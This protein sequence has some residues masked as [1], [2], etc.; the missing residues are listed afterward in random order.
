MNNKCA[1]VTGSAGLVGSA[2]ADL[3]CHHGWE[4]VGIDNFMRAEFFGQEAHTGEVMLDLMQRHPNYRHRR[5]DIRSYDAYDDIIQHYDLVV[6]CAGQP[7][8]DLAAKRP[9][10][11]WDVNATAT[12]RLLEFYRHT[13]P[14]AVFI[15]LSTNKVYGDS[16]NQFEYGESPL[17]YEPRSTKLYYFGVGETTLPV[18]QSLHSLFGVSKIAGD[19]MTQEY[20]RYFGLKTICFRCGCMTGGSHRGVKQHGFLAY[21]AKC[22]RENL[23]YTIIGYDGKQ[24]RDNLHADD[25]AMACLAAYDSMQE[26]PLHGEVFNLGGGRERS[27]SVLEALTYLQDETGNHINVSYEPLPRKGDH[28]WWI[29]NTAKFRDWASWGPAW[30]LD[31]IMKE[32]ANG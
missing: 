15:Y 30:T 4:V 19:F 29:T 13:C 24:V 7:S 31:A 12:V 25:V 2:V 23:P 1:L 21:L 26:R 3:L 6:H 32:L 18:D 14:E 11:D 10:D 17:R 22:V 5:R 16:I 27:V 8:H 9:M 28:I 20:G